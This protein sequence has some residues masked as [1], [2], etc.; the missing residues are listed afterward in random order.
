M[1]YIRPTQWNIA[2]LNAGARDEGFK[3]WAELKAS[4][5]TE[6][7]TISDRILRNIRRNKGKYVIPLTPAEINRLTKTKHT[8]ASVTKEYPDFAK[9]MK[10]YLDTKTQRPDLKN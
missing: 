5:D 8:W 2:E 1:V 3:S 10:E 9:G 4:T 7:Q 6:A